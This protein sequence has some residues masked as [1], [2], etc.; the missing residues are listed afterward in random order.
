[1]LAAAQLAE[2]V[3]PVAVA[4]A[5]VEEDAVDGLGGDD[6]AGLGEAGRGE[7]AVAEPLDG[8]A[9][10]LADAALVVDDEDGAHARTSG[11]TGAPREVGGGNESS[12]QVTPR[13]RA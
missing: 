5:D 6:A 8:G 3:E 1:M 4:E 7:G 11:R 10:A 2:Q 9:Q 13:S 12:K